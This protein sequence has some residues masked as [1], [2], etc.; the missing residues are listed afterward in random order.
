[1]DAGLQ[2]RGQFPFW[3]RGF[4][5]EAGREMV[6]FAFDDQSLHRVYAQAFSRNPASARVLQKIG[7]KHE[8]TLRHHMKKWDEYVDLECY[9]VLRSDFRSP[10]A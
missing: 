9:G 5:T 8:G 3:G 2:G 4:A 1:M 10:S 6:R 7:M